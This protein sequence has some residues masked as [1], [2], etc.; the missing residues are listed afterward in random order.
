MYNK[1]IMETKKK[2]LAKTL[3]WYAAHL[4]VATSVAL[5]VTHSLRIAAILASAEIAWE[6]ILF[7]SHERAWAKW[8]KS[9][10]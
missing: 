5:A 7:Y 2:S 6:A 3:T 4:T 1:F 9:L 8:G 10:K